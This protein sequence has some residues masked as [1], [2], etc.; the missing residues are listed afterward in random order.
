[1]DE[2]IKGSQQDLESNPEGLDLDYKA[3]YFDEIQ[4]AKKLRGRAQEAEA[5]IHS[6][7]KKQERSKIKNLQEQEQYK[8]L[9]ETLQT[10]LEDANTYKE[11]YQ[12][13]EANE[14]EEL[15]SILPEQDREAMHNESMQSLRYIAKQF[16]QSKTSVPEASLGMARGSNITKPYRDMDENERRAYFNDMSKKQR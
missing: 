4:N 6:Y 14:R 7:Q 12:T 10:Q 2:E 5:E 9:S 8:E 16:N 3:L 15:L 11:K 13:W 1:M